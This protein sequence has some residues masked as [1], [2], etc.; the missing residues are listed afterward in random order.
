MLE[1]HSEE[2]NDQEHTGEQ[3]NFL[4]KNQINLGS[5]NQPLFPP[6]INL[7]CVVILS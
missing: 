3:W 7:L 6:G 5:Q 2:T 4:H 1:Y